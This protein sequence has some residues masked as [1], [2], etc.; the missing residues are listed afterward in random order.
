[1]EPKQDDEHPAAGKG[2]SYVRLSMLPH[3]RDSFSPDRQRDM[4]RER[5]SRDGVNLI[6]EFSDLDIPARKNARR[7]GFE[8]AVK[9]LTERRI[10]T[11]SDHRLSRRAGPRRVRQHRMARLALARVQPAYGSI[12]ARIADLEEA[13]YLRGE[14]SNAAA[15]ARYER[16]RAKLVE[17]RDAVVSALD[18]LGHPPTLDV[19]ALLA[20]E[21]TQEAWEQTPL[22]RKR[23]LLRLAIQRVYVWRGKRWMQPAEERIRIVWVG[24]DETE[25]MSLGPETPRRRDGV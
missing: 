22:H 2:A 9:A 4:C 11:P 19:D 15:L 12:D 10:E 24:P 18:A 17:S 3:A 5:T 1:M 23:D 13:R 6:A 16:M 8:A 25:A 14:F 21:L 20:T 7:P